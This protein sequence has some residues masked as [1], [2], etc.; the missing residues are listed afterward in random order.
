MKK[1]VNKEKLKYDALYQ[2]TPEYGSANHGKMAYDIISSL[3]PESLLDVGC[4]NGEFCKWIHDNVCENVYGVDFS[5]SPSLKGPTW[6]RSFAHNIPVE[7]KSIDIITTFDMM[8]HLLEENIE[9]TLKEFKRIVV[10]NC[11]FNISYYPA[12]FDGIFGETLHPTIKPQDWWLDKIKKVF[13]T[14]DK[15]IKIFYRPIPN[16]KKKYSYIVLTV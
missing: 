6:I 16:T 14:E 1:R 15:K 11:V 8:E 12:S 9:E 4:G 3:E 5:S 10:K 13:K 7:D 2:H